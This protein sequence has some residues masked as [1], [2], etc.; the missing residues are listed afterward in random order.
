MPSDERTDLYGL[1]ATLHTCL[2]GEAIVVLFDA[3]DR[4]IDIA[5]G[6]SE[7]K[8]LIPGKSG[9]VRVRLNPLGDKNPVR[10]QA[11]VDATVYPKR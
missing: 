6:Y 1:A 4:I 9:T 7:Q 10:F 3:K 8:E 2:T 11:W 5:S